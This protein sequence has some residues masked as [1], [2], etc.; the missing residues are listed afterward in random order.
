MYV[1]YMSI[2]ILTEMGG[3]GFFDVTN[4]GFVGYT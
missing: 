2:W 1:L 3:M 4:V